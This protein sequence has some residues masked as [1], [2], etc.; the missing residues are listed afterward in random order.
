MNRDRVDDDSEQ[1]AGEDLWYVFFAL[2]IVIL[3]IAVCI[4]W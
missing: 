4:F 2:C 1:Y 3:I